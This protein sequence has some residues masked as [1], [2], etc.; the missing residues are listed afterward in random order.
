[1]TSELDL[2]PGHPL[3][4]PLT[5]PQ[6]AVVDV[7]SEIWLTQN[8]RWPAYGYVEREV[9]RRGHRL[10][11]V[12]PTF[13]AV[14]AQGF[15]AMVPEYRAFWGA[16]MNGPHSRMG[17]TVAGLAHLPTENQPIV[18]IYLA[19]VSAMA[20]RRRNAVLDP[21]K[22]E[23]VEITSSQLASLLNRLSDN[24]VTWMP[25]VFAHEPATWGG[26]QVA[27]DYTEP[28]W[29][30]RCG[31]ALR[32]FIDVTDVNDYLWRINAFLQPE[33]VGPPVEI[34]DPPMGLAASLDFLAAVWA[35][36]YGKPLLKLPS[37]TVV[38]SLALEA[39]TA[40]E[41]DSRLSALGQ[42]LKGLDAP[43]MP[44]VP[45]HP[46]QY[47]GARVLLD[48]P[49]EAQH[50]VQAA[51]DVL[52]AAVA[53]RNAVQHAPAAPKSVS[54]MQR[55]GLVYPISAWDAAWARIRTRVSVALTDLREEWQATL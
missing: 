35:L 46:V 11:E 47:L 14:R 48:V 19:A 16:A 20:S 1:M 52:E 34:P 40:D 38:T 24:W 39:E 25:A 17:L 18:Q 54:A 8:A 9:D 26:G 27:D 55:L 45:K 2:V 33:V 10:E 31:A 21:F 28:S 53:V 44:D 32:H 3:L 23:E 43:H 12:L 51:I 4:A 15:G 30:W 41:F 50:R 29:A 5:V 7:M 6:Q 49:T 13:P 22:P 36:K 37:A 42:I